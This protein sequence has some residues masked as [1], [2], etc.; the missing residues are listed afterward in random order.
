MNMQKSE[1]TET[2]KKRLAADALSVEE[3]KNNDLL[4]VVNPDRLPAVMGTLKNDPELCFTTLMNHLGADYKDKMAV[5]YNLYS[6]LLRGKVTVKAFLD[7]DKPEVPSLERL[8][9]GISWFERETYDLLGIRFIGHSNLKRLLLPEDWEGFPLK[10]DYVY[11]AEYNG[12]ST[13]RVDLMDETSDNGGPH[14]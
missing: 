11:P 9:R 8:F 6:P 14:V 4:V 13:A 10:K 12:L 7:H 2:I 1:I 5:I 3:R